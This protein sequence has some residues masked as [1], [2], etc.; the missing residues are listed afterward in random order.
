MF[1]LQKLCDEVPSYPTPEAIG[2]IERE[3]NLPVGSVFKVKPSLGEKNFR[4]KNQSWFQDLDN[5]VAPIAAAS[6]GQVYK[7]R[8]KADDSVVAVK[9]QRP[10]M[11]SSVLKDIYILRKFANVIQS[12]KKVITNQRP[13][14]VALV[15]NFAAAS[16]KELDYIAEAGNQERFRD[17]LAPKLKGGKRIKRT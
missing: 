11:L 10:D 13:Y 15:D 7:L 6:L 8:L 2:V 17:E 5:T 16:L 1:E 9:V 3:L 12:V 14:D 4:C